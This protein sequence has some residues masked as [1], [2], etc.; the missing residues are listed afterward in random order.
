MKFFISHKQEDEAIA[1]KVQEELKRNEADV[2]LDVLD[3]KISGGG[4]VLTNHIRKRLGECTDIIV[5]LSEKTKASWWVPFE[6]GMAAEKDMPTASYLVTGIALPDYLSF[7][8]RL[9]NGNDISTYINTRK[10]ITAKIHL[11]Q[12]LKGREKVM[13]ASN[14]SETERFYDELKKKL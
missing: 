13:Y 6:I 11:E 12:L 2:Y 7:W 10:E 3:D 4:R 8:P 9:K 14:Q 5:I 1:L